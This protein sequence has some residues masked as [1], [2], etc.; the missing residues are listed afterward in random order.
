[1]RPVMS[2]TDVTMR[3]V[4]QLELEMVRSSPA[5]DFSFVFM[6]QCRGAHFSK[7]KHISMVREI[8]TIL[9]K[10]IQIPEEDEVGDSSVLLQIRKTEDM[11]HLD[12]RWCIA[13]AVYPHT[14]SRAVVDVCSRRTGLVKTISSLIL[15]ETPGMV[16]LPVHWTPS[17]EQGIGADSSS[18]DGGGLE[19]DPLRPPPL[20]LAVRCRM[21]AKQ[22]TCD[23]LPSDPQKQQVQAK[24]IGTLLRQLLTPIP[25]GPG[26]TSCADCTSVVLHCVLPILH[27]D[28]HNLLAA[29]RVLREIGTGLLSLCAA[30]VMHMLRK[31][32]HEVVSVSQHADGIVRPRE[33]GHVLSEVMTFACLSE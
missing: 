4:S 21:M 16:N 15:R 13:C 25:C 28:H 1:M 29:L 12:R 11:P 33:I 19:D 26:C 2:Y 10:L 23:G 14:A 3:H 8:S 5:S 18:N 7:T 30:S 9:N 6:N 31:S 17:E 24:N 32:L 22:D 27:I 20:L